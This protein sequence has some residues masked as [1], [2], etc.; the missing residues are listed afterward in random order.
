MSTS[1]TRLSRGAIAT[2]MVLLAA[3][4]GGGTTD[5]GDGDGLDFVPPSIDILTPEDTTT[6]VDRAQ[7]F[8]MSVDVADN[9][10]LRRVRMELFDG[11]DRLFSRD[12]TFL[13]ADIVTRHI[14]TGTADISD[15]DVGKLMHMIVTAYDGA[16]NQFSDSLPFLTTSIGAPPVEVGPTVRLEMPA[17]TIMYPGREVRFRVTALDPD[18]IAQIAD[19]IRGSGMPTT[20]QTH[21]VVT[22]PLLDSLSIDTVF[23]IPATTQ[24]GTNIFFVGVA[25][26]G[27]GQFG[28]A[29]RRRFIIERQPGDT[30]GPLVRQT[31]PL[32]LEDSASFTVRAED[33]GRVRRIGYRV[34][35]S[36]GLHIDSGSVV[37]TTTTSTI[38]TQEFRIRFGP[39][40]RG[41]TVIVYSFADDTTG[42]RGYSVATN[43]T[44]PQMNVANARLDRPLLVY[45]RTFALPEGGAGADVAVD[46]VSSRRIVYVSNFA[47]NRLEAWNFSNP[48]NITRLSPVLVGS[49]PWGM[50]L[51]LGGSR[52]LVANSG[53]T[54][55]SVVDLTSRTEVDRYRTPN[56]RLWYV[57][58]AANADGTV[59]YTGEIF[60]YS[61]RPQ[62]V[63]MSQ[64]G[65]IYFSTRPT[66]TAPAGTIRRI[67]PDVPGELQQIWQ[68]GDES[69][70]GE[71]SVVNADAVT[72][73]VYPAGSDQIEI[74]DHP[75]GG[76]VS[77]ICFRGTSV[78]GL[79]ASIRA[80][81]GD[82]VAE[83]VAAASLALTDTT[84]VDVG[85]D[86]RW[87]A[88]G[89]GNTEGRPGRIMMVYDPLGST[90]LDATPGISVRDL[91]DNASDRVTGVAINSNSST[92]GVHGAEAYFAEVN[93]DFRFQLRLQGKFATSGSGSGIVFHPLND[94]T[95]SDANT[96]R[97]AVVAAGEPKLQ[98]IDTYFFRMRG[99]IPLQAPLFGPLRAIL[100][101]PTE[102]ASGVVMK[103]FGLS[104]GGLVIVDVL[105]SDIAP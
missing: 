62:Y 42:N 35:T 44:V 14:M 93:D 90:T 46:S 31:V 78:T 45:G 54:N 97:I 53:G 76:T 73:F 49:Q 63:A 17:D 72:I 66:S 60:D 28:N 67:D 98:I 95:S 26:D 52:L 7:P 43:V 4:S 101:T 91:T 24:I 41:Q 11:L 87:V 25:R 83:R 12:T 34:T 40:Y 84:F 3:C 92:V 48:A 88:F 79:T 65:N 32:R 1:L 29:V 96:R 10:E 18:G 99:E 51:E 89:E 38:D 2:L 19:T 100:P 105:A 102:A 75:V 80:A 9:S 13:G 81:G 23:N 68:Y 104:A 20:I 59:K 37:R 8:A 5:G 58:E 6:I 30:L 74:C 33:L 39:Q 21:D 50:A 57:K 22:S 69:P 27:R 56:A 15:R 61:D 64:N 47:Q 77:S 103:I 71:Y 36:A 85:G 82:A 70:I 16:G 94:G 86:R 55:L